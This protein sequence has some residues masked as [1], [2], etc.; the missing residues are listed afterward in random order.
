MPT[1][2]AANSRCQSI[3]RSVT[4]P[5]RDIPSLVPH[6]TIR[7][8]RLIGPSRPSE[9]MDANSGELGEDVLAH[10]LDGLHHLGYVSGLEAAVQPNISRVP[11]CQA[12]SRN[13]GRHAV[14]ICS[15]CRSSVPQQPP[16][17]LS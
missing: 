3:S 16:I 11:A 13:S 1:P 14:A 4:S 5:S 2:P 9:K 10:E 12:T 17:T 7:L 6:F 15:M 8:R